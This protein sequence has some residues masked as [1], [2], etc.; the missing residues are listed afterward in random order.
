MSSYL[1]LEVLNVHFVRKW[2]ARCQRKVEMGSSALSVQI[3]KLKM[4]QNNSFSY[5]SKL[6]LQWHLPR[7]IRKRSYQLKISCLIRSNVLTDAFWS[8]FT[9]D[10]PL[11]V[12]RAANGLGAV[13][14][15]TFAI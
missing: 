14:A 11:I 3:S 15:R 2:D 13:T 12:Q 5:C 7:A 1:S 10:K 4:V 8:M 6:N 9:F